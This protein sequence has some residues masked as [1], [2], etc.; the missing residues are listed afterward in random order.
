MATKSICNVEGC[1]KRSITRGWCGSHYER[2]FNHGDPLGGGTFR[3]ELLRYFNEVVMAYEGDECLIWPYAKGGR[4]YGQ[5]KVAGVR[6][7]VH[8]RVCEEVN[9]S[10]PTPD[11]EAAHSCGH[12]HEGCVTKG[13][14]SWKTPAENQADRIVH[15]TH[16]RGGRNPRA[17]LTADD[18]REIRSLNDQI[19]EKE[20][21]ERFGVSSSNISAIRRGKSW[22]WLE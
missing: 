6:H 20:I 9:G 1:G 7:Y 22:T 10:P 19:V 15:G 12:G 14:L 2:W 16:G 21:A 5:M 11:H 18:V 4:G 3:G 8:R 13:H 17:K